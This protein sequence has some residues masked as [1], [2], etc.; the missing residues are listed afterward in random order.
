MI[1]EQKKRLGCHWHKLTHPPDRKRTSCQF[2]SLK[3]WSGVVFCFRNVHVCRFMFI[4]WYY[5]FIKKN[6]CKWI[7]YELFKKKKRKANKEHVWVDL[8]CNFRRCNFENAIFNI[9]FIMASGLNF[10]IL[11]GFRENLYN[12]GSSKFNE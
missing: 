9:P 6:S 5:A 1:F 7:F 3:L 2:L 12:L 4:V 10:K 11:N 8:D